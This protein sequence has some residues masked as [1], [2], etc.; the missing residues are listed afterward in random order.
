MPATL[1]ILNPAS[2]HGL[3]RKLRPRIERALR[4]T[5]VGFDLVETTAPGDAVRLGREA[6]AAGVERIL[7]AGG[8]GT[9]HE[10]ANG[11]L[12]A[13]SAADGA[14]RPALG[15][16]PI[17][18]GNDFAKL[19]HVYKLPPE[20]AARRMAAARVERFDVGRVIGEY[21]DNSLGIGFDA[22]V[23]RQ[24][25][26]T[27][28]LSGLAVYVVAVYKTFV[29]FRAPMLEVASAAHSETGPMM[30]LE[31][32]IGRSAGGGFY[33]TPDADP[34]DGLLDVCLIRKVGLAKFLRY[35]P[36]VL[37][38]KHVG[39]A[40]VAMFRTAAL[41]IRSTDRPLLLHLDGEVRAPDSRDIEVTLEAGRLRVLVGA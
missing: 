10:V 9:V 28:K 7:A 29:S 15:T 38:G 36:R 13:P 14:T 40:E 27:T 5:G 18:T 4:E 17:G 1:L 25:N 11:L 23:A 20:E 3:G 8:D 39:L 35:V 26:Q 12:E 41:K 34:A 30:M 21:F 33:L 2:G 24:A 32:S 16:I 31:C 6:A 37:S 19:L 22:E